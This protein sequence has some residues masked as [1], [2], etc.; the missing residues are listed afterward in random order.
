M[1]GRRVPETYRNQDWP[2]KVAQLVNTIAS[3]IDNG[4]VG[5]G[6]NGFADYNDTTGDVSVTADTWTAL[7]NNGAGAFTNL[8]YMP[9]GVT[10]L[11][12]TTTGKIDVSELELG[13]TILI[14]TDFTVTPQ[15]NNSAVDFRYTLGSGASSYVLEHQLGRL[16]RGAGEDYR[17]ALRADLI[18]MGDAN[19][20]DNPIG[21]EVKCSGGA[22]MNNAGAVIQV[23]KRSA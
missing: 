14:R 6:N 10:S 16:D 11:M 5:G 22:T 18:Y 19:T 15:T 13:D 12:D 2:R 7:P 21:L 1:I 9:D 4:E 20:R 8:A 23:I 17:F 3:K